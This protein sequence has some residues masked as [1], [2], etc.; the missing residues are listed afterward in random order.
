MPEENKKSKKGSSFLKLAL[1][2]IILAIIAVVVLY[3][4]FDI[5]PPSFYQRV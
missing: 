5:S 4:F 3:S 1:F 2:L